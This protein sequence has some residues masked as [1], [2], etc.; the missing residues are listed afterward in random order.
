LS[1]SL[2]LKAEEND[3]QNGT[4]IAFLSREFCLLFWVLGYRMTPSEES[5]LAP[6]TP[7]RGVEEL[8]GRLLGKALQTRV[9]LRSTS[10]SPSSVL[11]PSRLKSSMLSVS[12]A[13]EPML[14]LDELPSKTVEERK[15][16]RGGWRCAHDEMICT[17]LNA[18][19]LS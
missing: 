9:S 3:E 1:F 10:F 16:E 11:V 15:A 7:I 4:L 18:P 2:S 14:V 13:I 12:I 17:S 6:S 8:A 5:A 19:S